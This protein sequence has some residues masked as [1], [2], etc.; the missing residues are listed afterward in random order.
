M[1]YNAKAMHQDRISRIIE[2]RRTSYMAEMRGSEPTAPPLEYPPLPPPDY[3]TS[4]ST[5]NSN[6]ALNQT[7]SDMQRRNNDRARKSACW[8]FFGLPFRASVIAQFV[9]CLLGS[10]LHCLFQ[11]LWIVISFVITLACLIVP[12]I[13]MPMLFATTASWRMISISELK[14]L[15]WMYRHSTVSF[16]AHFRPA[17]I[18][19]PPASLHV[20]L[21]DTASLYDRVRERAKRNISDPFTWIPLYYVPLIKLPMTLCMMSVQAIMFLTSLILMLNWIV[22]LICQEQCYDFIL[23]NDDTQLLHWIFQPGVGMLVTIPF[24]IVLFHLTFMYVDLCVRWM[25]RLAFLL[26]LDEL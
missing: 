13:G 2:E 5:M 21:P 4:I 9:Y 7:D 14:L 8:V 25:Y 15:E 26:F 16:D 17:R 6:T 22:V 10:L 11:L 3:H 12:P 18:E 24:G 23:R 19:Y 20:Y 1:P